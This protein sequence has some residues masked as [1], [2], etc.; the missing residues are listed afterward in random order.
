MHFLLT[1]YLILWH[2]SLNSDQVGSDNSGWKYSTIIQ[3]VVGTEANTINRTD[4]ENN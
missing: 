1:Y 3:K 2:D 4:K